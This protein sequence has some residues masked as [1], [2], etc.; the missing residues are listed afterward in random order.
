MLNGYFNKMKLR[1]QLVP[2]FE[3]EFLNYFPFL[4]ITDP[5]CAEVIHEIDQSTLIPERGIVHSPEFGYMP[6]DRISGGAKCLLLLYARPDLLLYASAMG[7]NCSYMLKK[8]SDL[9]DC[10]LWIDYA[11]PF[12][13]DQAIHFPQYNETAY[14]FK[15]YLDIKGRHSDDYYVQ[16]CSG[17]PAGCPDNYDVNPEDFYYRNLEDQ[18]C[19]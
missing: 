11:F 2:A 10:R 7:E 15:E 16:V 12:Q 6:V 4:K 9:V 5:I 18:E 14:S 1:K 17:I 3:R 13:S 8:V 19:L